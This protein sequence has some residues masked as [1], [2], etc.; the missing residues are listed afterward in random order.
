MEK[1]NHCCYIKEPSG[2]TTAVTDE[3]FLKFLHK[4]YPIIKHN[5]KS[6]I[7]QTYK[8]YG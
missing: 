6:T 4:G 7:I 1:N 2:E 5:E 3:L 8:N